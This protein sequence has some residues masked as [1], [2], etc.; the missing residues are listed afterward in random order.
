[1]MVAK[2]QK[3][4]VDRISG[5]PGFILH[6]ILSMFDTKEAGRASVLSKRWYGAWSSIP[7]L[8]FQY[9]YFQKCEDRPYMY[10][11][12]MFERFVGFIDKTM[13]RYLTKKYRI[14]E[15]YLDIALPYEKRETS[16]DKWIMIAVQN[17]IQKLEIKIVVLNRYDYSHRLPEILFC[18][19]SLK[20]LKCLKVEL[21]YYETMEL[22]S[23]KYLTLERGAVNVDMLQRII[24]FCPL[25]ELDVTSIHDLE[26]DSLSCMGKVNGGDEGRGSG[27]MQAPSLQKFVGYGYFAGLLP[28]MVALKNLKKLEFDCAPVTDDILSELVYV[29][30]ALETLVLI[31]CSTLE[32]IKISSNSLTQLRI[33]EG[34]HLMKVTIDTPNLLEFSYN[35]EMETSLSLISVLDHY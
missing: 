11:E 8:D 35:C 22:T 10:D 25:I 29:L 12:D 23:L 16:I 26:E 3:G 27:T 14:T 34:F 32:C 13:Q 20:Y 7:V 17:Q 19:K 6:T 28:H 24:S 15:M 18:A 21:P 33:E 4:T 2:M 5:L 30:V 1:M 9:Q 31:G